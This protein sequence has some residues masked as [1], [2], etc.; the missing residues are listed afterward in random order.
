MTL[1]AA[2]KTGKRRR[3]GAARP[4]AL[5]R[6]CSISAKL[7]LGKVV[8]ATGS[9]KLRRAGTATVTLK[10]AAKRRRALRRVKRKSLKVSVMR[11]EAGKK[12][13]GTRR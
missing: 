1:V 7:V 3:E 10:V 9:A 5:H 12:L 2:P 11:T 8:Y 13:A 6:A 4:R